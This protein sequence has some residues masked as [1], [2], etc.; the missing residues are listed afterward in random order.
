VIWDKP[1]SL[2]LEIT[3]LSGTGI[4]RENKGLFWFLSFGL[5]IL[6]ALLFIIPNVITLGPPGIKNNGI[7]LNSVT[8]RGFLG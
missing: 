6:G 5:G 2:S 7:F 8:N 4:V 1:H 3:R